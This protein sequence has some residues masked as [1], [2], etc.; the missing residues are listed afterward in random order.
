LRKGTWAEKGEDVS[1]DKPEGATHLQNEKPPDEE[2][3]PEELLEVAAR[4]LSARA[5]IPDPTDQI[6]LSPNHTSGWPAGAPEGVTIHT[7]EGWHD[8]SVAWLRNPES[9]ASAHFCIRRDGKIVQLVWERDRA[10][11]ARSSGMYYFGIEHEGGSGLGD[12]PILWKTGRNADD[13]RED[14]HMLIQSARLVAYLCT[15]HAI[16]IQHDFERPP[17]R[18]SVSHIAGHDQMMGND[19]RDPG[20]EFPWRA[21][22]RRVQRFA[23]K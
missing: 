10:W 14:D 23:N 1:E 18:D 12:I 21:Y 20:P 15:K 11:H 22:M 19:H 3:E 16:R 5:S 9:F 17:V 7:E 13:L 6:L 8:P 4:A 2:I